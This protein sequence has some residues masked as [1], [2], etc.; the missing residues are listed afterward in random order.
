MSLTRGKAEL[1]FIVSKVKLLYPRKKIILFGQSFGGSICIRIN[2]E[3]V[4]G[5]ILSSPVLN[6]EETLMSYFKFK[7]IKDISR[8]EYLYFWEPINF[9][10]KLLRLRVKSVIIQDAIKNFDPYVLA[11]KIITPILIFRGRNDRRL[12]EK[13]VSKFFEKIKSKKKQLTVIDGG[14]HNALSFWFSRTL[15]DE[16]YLFLKKNFDVGSEL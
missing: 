15:S 16:I 1:E 2:Q 8:G 10:I 14:A 7:N 9:P 5:L 6:I 3:L 4:D 12:G 13:V 11:E